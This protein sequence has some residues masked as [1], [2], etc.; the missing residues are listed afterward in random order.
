MTNLALFVQLLSA[1]MNSNN[2][3]PVFVF[4]RFL[5]NQS[6]FR[7]RHQQT[8]QSISDLVTSKQLQEEKKQKNPKIKHRKIPK[9][10]TEKSQNSF[11]SISA[12]SSSSSLQRRHRLPCSVVIILRAA[13]SSSS[14]C[15]VFPAA[16]SSSSLQRRHRLPCSVVIILRAASSSSS[17]WLW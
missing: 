1:S 14:A 2:Q 6:S 15:S 9:S 12:A 16:S 11:Q 7:S 8:L 10:N 3:T 4:L 5:G 13:S 17:A